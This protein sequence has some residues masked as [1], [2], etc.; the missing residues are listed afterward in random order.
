[1]SIFHASKFF[2]LLCAK[3]GKSMKG[4]LHHLFPVYRSRLFSAEKDV[5]EKLVEMSFNNDTEEQE[6]IFER[7]S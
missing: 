1:M 5:T 7:S 4:V 3:L 6:E 2:N